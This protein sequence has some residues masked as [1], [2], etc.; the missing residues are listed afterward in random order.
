MIFKNK[1]ITTKQVLYAKKKDSDQKIDI[2][3]IIS[4]I[5]DKLTKDSES[6]PDK[7]DDTLMKQVLIV[8]EALVDSF[9][10]KSLLEPDI[11]KYSLPVCMI[12]FYLARYL[13]INNLELVIEHVS[14]TEK[15]QE[16]ISKL[17]NSIEELGS[18]PEPTTTKNWNIN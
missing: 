15:E 17:K 7:W 11:F 1:D 3:D 12:G 4:E 2:K 5:N 13:Q 14:L 16:F 9:G 8:E 18:E 10:V 6:N